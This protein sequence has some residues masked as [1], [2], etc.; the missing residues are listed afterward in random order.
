VLAATV[1][2]LTALPADAKTVGISASP[3]PATVGSHVRHTLDVGAPGRLEVWV[4]ATGFQQPG[5]GTLPSGAWSFECCP[6]Q[7]GG[8]SAWRYRSFG[9]VPPGSY[10]FAAVARARGTYLST[11]MVLGA[12]AGV[13]IRIV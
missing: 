8:T 11:A 6:S 1:V 9:I 5:P 2:A 7:V 3:N 4:S 10:R 13:S 12:S